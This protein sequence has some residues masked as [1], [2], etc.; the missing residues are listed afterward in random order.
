MNK[1]ALTALEPE[2]LEVLYSIENDTSMWCVS[3]TNAPY[4]HYALR[5]YISSQQYD[6]YADKQ[7]RFVIRVDGKAVGLI[8]L[9]NF[10]PQHLRAEMGVA[11][12]KE[13]QGKGYAEQAIR[14]LQQYCS[15]TLNLHQIYSI[16]PVNNAPSIAMLQRTGFDEVAK[17][18]EWL[19]SVNGWKDALMLS[20]KF[21]E[22]LKD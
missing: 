7:V 20:Y 10:S 21:D 3:D 9:F 6:I 17:L 18:D 1:V 13:E 12:L 2:D 15:N 22:R 8:D 11:V 5:S 4:S 19:K 16:V 14:L